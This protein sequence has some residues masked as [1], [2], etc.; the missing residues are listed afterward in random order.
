MT[1]VWQRVARLFTTAADRSS[2]DATDTAMMARCIALSREAVDAGEYPFA[3]VIAQGD[4]VVVEATNRVARDRDVTHHAELLAIS[5]AQR[6]IGTGKLKGCTLYSTVEPCPMCSFPIRE[7]G[8]GRVVFAIRSPLMG[9]HSRW[10]V[11]GDAVLSSSMPEVFGAAPTVAVGASKG[12]RDGVVAHEPV[13]LG[14]HPHA[15]RVRRQRAGVERRG[16]PAR[17]GRSERGIACTSLAT[18]IRCPGCE[19]EYAQRLAG[20]HRGCASVNGS[21]TWNAAPPSRFT[22]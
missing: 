7:V 9:G 10:D 14:R 1:S 19:R 22:R 13:G 8:I 2:A 11:L 15:R 21:V 20:S 16:A 3:C 5:E 18:V 17:T 12:S 4:E 6:K